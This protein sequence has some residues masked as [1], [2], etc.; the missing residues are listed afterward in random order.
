MALNLGF[1]LRG[2]SGA[3][4]G[5]ARWAPA[6]LALHPSFPNPFNPNTTIR[7]DLPVASSVSLIVRDIAG[8][9]VRHL[10]AGPRSAGH[11]SAAWDGRDDAGRPVG[12]GVYLCELRAGEF[13]VVRKMLLMN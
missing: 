2:G 13:R 5:A 10:D 11:H 3:A 7:Y 12:S 9:V 4:E 1:L 6:R 8:R